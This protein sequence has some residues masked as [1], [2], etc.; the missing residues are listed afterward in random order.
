MVAIAIDFFE[1][2]DKFLN[3]ALSLRQILFEYYLNFIPWINGLLWPLFAF[4][5]VIFFTSRMASNSEIVSIL[6]AG[7][8]YRRLLRPYL[9]A[10]T[11]IAGLLWIGKNYVIPASNKVKNEFESIYIKRSS[12]KALSDNIHLF[13][14]PQEKVYIRYFRKS[15][16]T[17]QNF[18]LERYEDG[19]LVHLLKA[20]KLAYKE[21]PNVWTMYDYE[22]H[23][24][25][26]I[27]EHLQLYKNPKD[28]TLNITPTDF[29]RYERQMEMMSTSDLKDFIEKEEGRGIDTALK[30]KT[31]YYQRTSDPFTIIILTILGVAIASR[32]VR[33]GLG[34]HLAFGI[35]L[36]SGFIILSKFSMTFS[37]NLNMSPAI[38]AWMPNIIFGIV[39][40]LMLRRAQK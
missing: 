22:H 4:L 27:K 21:D 28:T 33:G 30:Y 26:G 18:M 3:D 12:K 1:K 35:I 9:I 36:G 10:A 32:K 20:R 37:T 8:S 19:E 14:S 5:S 6:S 2:V 25:D 15:D 39:T 34:L 23:S 16:S 38:G 24:F 29:I 7:I 13:I 31:E 17:A 40:L 11:I